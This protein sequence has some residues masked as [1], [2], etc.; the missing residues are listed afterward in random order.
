MK[1]GIKKR[2]SMPLLTGNLQTKISINAITLPLES[3]T[4]RDQTNCPTKG[5][6]D[7]HSWAT[8][9]SHSAS[10]D[11]HSWTTHTVLIKPLESILAVSCE[12]QHWFTQIFRISSQTLPLKTKLSTLKRHFI[13]PYSHSTFIHSCPQLEKANQIALYLLCLV[14]PLVSDI[15]LERFSVISAPNISLISPSLQ[16]GVLVLWVSISPDW[17]TVFSCSV[18]LIPSFFLFVLSLGSRQAYAEAHWPFPYCVLWTNGPTKGNLHFFTGLF[19]FC[20][21]RVF[22]SLITLPTHSYILS[23]LLF[24]VNQNYLKFLVWS[25][26]HICC[27]PAGVWCLLS[28]C[29]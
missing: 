14:C 22:I 9:H 8:L 17:P 2:G 15:N 23:M 20:F 21:L 5:W 4:L 12:A 10:G 28:L 6:W 19:P 13:R 16:P 25:L 29:L 18:Q 7:A 27:I 24:H 11:V 3:L 1:K 26:Q